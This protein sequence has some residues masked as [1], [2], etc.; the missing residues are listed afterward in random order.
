MCPLLAAGELIF[1]GMQALRQP[2]LL[3]HGQATLLAQPPPRPEDEPSQPLE[4]AVLLTGDCLTNA[5]ISWLQPL[6]VAAVARTDVQILALPISPFN[7]RLQ[8]PLLRLLQRRRAQP[9]R[10]RRRRRRRAPRHAARGTGR[11]TPRRGSPS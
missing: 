2:L 6:A 1:A 10:H 7:G 9:R 3:L 8:L 4:A 11:E 5:T